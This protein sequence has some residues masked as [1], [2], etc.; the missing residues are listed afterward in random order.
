MIEVPHMTTWFSLPTHN[1]L[2][3]LVF[4]YLLLLSMSSVVWLLKKQNPQNNY[5]ELTKR[6]KTFWVIAGLLGI[7]LIIEPNIALLFWGFVSYLALKEYFTIIPTR[8]ID[9]RVLFWAYIAIPIQYYW[10]A[11]DWYAM[12]N[13]FIPVYFFLFMP[14]RMV[15]LGDTK[16]FLR[17]LGTVHWGVMMMVYCM[18]YIAAFYMLEPSHNPAGGIA[19]FILYLLFLNQFNDVAQFFWGKNF[20]R[21]KIIPAVSPNKTWEGFLGGVASTTLLSLL[22]APFITPFST[23]HA[24]VLGILIACSGFIGDVGMSALKRDLNLKDTG[25]MLPGHGG[26]LDRIDSLLFTTPLYFHFINY[27]YY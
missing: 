5:S 17:S 19:G 1:V 25:Q 18:S 22:T 16:G 7:S 11:D 6:F 15:I 23:W 14:F 8:Q 27:F 21:H 3:C 26:V 4:V 2:I 9:R 13:I 20:G 24:F 10:I 12:F